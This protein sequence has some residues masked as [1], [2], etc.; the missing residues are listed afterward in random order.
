[1]PR[2]PCVRRAPSAQRLRE[3]LRHRRETAFDRA[4]SRND[5]PGARSAEAAGVT[6][7]SR[8]ANDIERGRGVCLHCESELPAGVEGAYCCNGCRAV[9]ELLKSS[10][11]SRYYTLRGGGSAPV[12]LG[13]ASRRDLA[14]LE[15]IESELGARE[16]TTRLELDVAGMHC[17]GCVWVQQELFS[18]C[19]G[20]H[21]IV[22]NPALGRV[23][24]WVDPRFPLRSFVTELERFGYVLGPKEK[25]DRAELDGLL[26]RTGVTLALAMNAM[27][28]ALAIYFGLGDGPFHALARD[29][30]IVLAGIAVAIGAPVFVRGAWAGLRARVLHLDVPIALGLL[31]ASVGTLWAYITRGDASYADTLAVFVALM[32]LGRWLSARVV[33]QS[34]DR[35]LASAGAD[36]LYAR[37]ELDGLPELVRASAIAAGDVLRVAP[38]E[39]VVVDARLLDDSASLSLDWIDG[40]SQPRAFAKGDTVPAG[41]ITC[42]ARTL[43]LSALTGFARSP[44]VD[45]LGRPAPDDV[46]ASGSRFWDR[47]VRVYV[48]GVLA[49][50]AATFV[51]WLAASG[52]L[53][54]ALEI[55]TAVLVVTCPCG[56]GIATPLAYELAH[57]WLR[58]R[59]VFVRRSRALDRAPE[60]TRVV[61]D[62]TGTL[63]TGRS[64]LL[65]EAVLSGLSE[66]DRRAIATLAAASSH[67]KSVAVAEALSGEALLPA[68]DL[69]ELAGRGVRA[70]IGGHELRLGAPEW[71]A[72]GA[73]HGGDLAASRDGVLLAELS[74][75]ETLRHDALTEI[76]ALREQGYALAILSGDAD[77]RVRAVAAELGI[78]DALGKATPSAKAEWLSQHQAEKALFVGDGIND[79]PAIESAGISGTPS[80]DRP[81]LPS[82]ADFY[83]V[84]PGLSPIRELLSVGKRL[85]R[86]ARGNLGFALAY[87]A[88]A[89]S[90]AAAGM[91]RPWLAAILM[92]ASS[93]AVIVATAARMR[94]RSAS[95]RERG[96]PRRS[97]PSM[98]MLAP[99]PEA[100]WKP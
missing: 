86:V 72:P 83:F 38:G 46:A 39:V 90:I 96:A 29:L 89:V 10:G 93:I 74:T 4:Q 91:M 88:F 81:F 36:G 56:I 13:D 5:A 97:E 70:R 44:L 16:G 6:A 18:R 41:A 59:G 79:A 69:E 25:A 71:A 30:E 32:L 45:L 75:R 22:P 14:W 42:G 62:K 37:R 66:D 80:I 35:L 47:V 49:V 77:A 27:S 64:E 68:E 95:A 43:R 52:D 55:T 82:K 33:R 51:G 63:T 12:S 87:N 48:G 26:L 65:D 20:A 8:E 34:R 67:P 94:D 1:M 19:E 24:L 57:A 9:G 85:R 23:E 21:R 78:V 15:P 31:L 60:I 76:A 53:S 50:A 58:R 7:P 3:S 2:M 54:H 98:G 99:S 73:A 11:L 92:P 61:L 84:A 17:A 100:A 40:E 28:F